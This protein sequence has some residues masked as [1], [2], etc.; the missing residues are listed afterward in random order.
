MKST[1][2]KWFTL[3]ELIIVITIL[4]ILATIAFISFQ[5]YT[6]DA[7][8]SRVK[9]DIANVTKVIS[10]RQAESSTPL[11]TFISWSV[12]PANNPSIS[13][14]W[15]WSTNYASGKLNTTVIGLKTENSFDIATIE[16][17]GWVY[18]V[19]WALETTDTETETT[20]VSGNYYPRA[21]QTFTGTFSTP[22][23]TIVNWPLWYLQKWDIISN[24]TGTGTITKIS[25]DL[26]TITLDGMTGTPTSLNL[27][28]ESDS[29][30]Q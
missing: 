27:P 12:A 5:S 14:Q 23:F 7:R 8:N 13:V 10:I 1:N 25:S 28:K 24:W 17:L 6:K 11:V 16:N 26:K 22:D 20:Y 30:F 15:T 19:K 21:A 29:L 3:V 4:A 2:T 9:S 18:Q